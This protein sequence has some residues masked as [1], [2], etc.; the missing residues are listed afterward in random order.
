MARFCLTNLAKFALLLLA[1]SLVTFALV[2]LSPV[3]PVQANLGQAAYAGLSDAKR[4]QL[5]AYW[6]TSVPFPERYANWLAAAVQGDL[7]VSLRY[8]A[9]V[10]QV[11]ATRAANSL[12]LMACAWVASG[13]LGFALGITAG[14][15]RG[16]LVDRIV[17]GYCYL[18][19]ST[20]VFWLGL[21]LLI[22]F[23]VELGWFPLG[24]S[25]PVGTASAD[26]T[27][28]DALH[29]LA[30]PAIT[31][32]ITGVANIALH[33]REKT[34]DVLESDYVRFAKAR[35]DSTASIV[36]HHGL[37]NL[38]LPALTLQ[39]ASISEL[40]GGSVL[41]EEVFSYPGLGQAA[42]TAGLGGDAALL[43]GIAV[44][45]AALVFGGNLIANV[46]YGVVDPRMRKGALQ[47]A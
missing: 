34:I 32:S 40:F 27:F 15:C 33:T 45:S 2:S 8:N 24:F 38:A 20:P 14:I 19:A 10:A 9:P 7:G 25:V 12:A 5:E 11:I 28:A 47:D 42:V 29:H 41:V 36:W 22:V 46:L 35:G 31:L 43:A 18:L 44:A 37:R 3:D 23:S 13:V 6:G 39:F 30:L 21:V 26:V 1:V 17:K 4:A 16:R